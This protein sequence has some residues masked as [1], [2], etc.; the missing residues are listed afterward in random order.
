MSRTTLELSRESRKSLPQHPA[1]QKAVR[2]VRAANIVFPATYDGNDDVNSER[3]GE[4]AGEAI[5][6][7]CKEL[8]ISGGPLWDTVNDLIL[9]R[10]YLA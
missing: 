7:A 3:F 1:I 4:V 8:G 2:V 6:T 5:Q 9:E 10:A